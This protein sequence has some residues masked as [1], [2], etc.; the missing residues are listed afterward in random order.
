M[1]TF[2]FRPASSSSQSSQW[3]P[4]Y[5]SASAVSGSS[6]TSYTT[7]AAWWSTGSCYTTGNRII[8]YEHH[9]GVLFSSSVWT[10][11]DFL[12]LSHGFIWALR[13]FSN[14]VHPVIVNSS[15]MRHSL[16]LHSI[17]L[18]LNCCYPCLSFII[19]LN[20][21]FYQWHHTWCSLLSL[22]VLRSFNKYLILCWL[23]VRVFARD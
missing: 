12:P 13:L 11:G 16:T 15:C 8:N 6:T 3:C 7:N 2:C 1:Y 18:R 4:V 19:P 22:Q 5:L 23:C 20:V 14:A 9:D 21:L 17:Y 10:L